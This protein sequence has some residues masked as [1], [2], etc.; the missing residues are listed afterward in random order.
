MGFFN[1]I[2]G[3]KN[4]AAETE[5]ETSLK[6]LPGKKMPSYMATPNGA[7]YG[8]WNIVRPYNAFNQM[9]RLEP[10]VGQGMSKRKRL[11]MSQGWEFTPNPNNPNSDEHVR[12]LQEDAFAQINLFDMFETFLNAIGYGFQAI[13]VEY[14]HDEQGNQV[15]VNWEVIPHTAFEFWDA[16]FNQSGPAVEVQLANV[17]GPGQGDIREQYPYNLMWYIS[18]K[19]PEGDPRGLSALGRAYW[20]NKFKVHARYLWE[21]FG[22]RFS[23]P[24]LIGQFKSQEKDPDKLTA[25]ANQIN[26]QLTNMRNAAVGALANVDVKAL[27]VK[28]TSSTFPD[29][30]TFCDNEIDMAIIGTNMLSTPTGGSYAL[31][32]E[33]GEMVKNQA[34]GDAKALS[35]YIEQTLIKWLIDA[36][37]GEQPD[38]YPTMPF[39]FQ[40]MASFEDLMKAVDA[41]IPMD[42]DKFYEQSHLPAPTE[43]GDV[44]EVK[45]SGGTAGALTEQVLNKVGADE[46]VKILFRDSKKKS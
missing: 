23:V 39:N 9:M 7:C 40:T 27:E 2:F 33:H 42:R 4:F 13:F 19:D 41:G 43:D 46:I 8:F 30:V 11:V 18:E 26:A 20:Y 37:Y 35:S 45:S 12:F 15:L 29:I 17:M 28:S 34:E 36:N 16:L 32:T 10:R 3:R 24:S 31:S 5:R 6:A 44:L 22:E 21:Q 1:K 14:G 25:I 38:G